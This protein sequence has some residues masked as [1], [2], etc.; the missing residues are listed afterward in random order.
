MAVRGSIPKLLLFG[1]IMKPARCSHTNAPLSL[2]TLN[3]KVVT[4]P[5]HGA[6]FA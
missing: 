4:C 6:K 5:L 2:G 3:G 1:A